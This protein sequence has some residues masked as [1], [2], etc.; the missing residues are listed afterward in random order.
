MNAC[1]RIS[2]DAGRNASTIFEVKCSTISAGYKGGHGNGQA[3]KHV[4]S[5]GDRTM[6]GPDLERAAGQA[7]KRKWQDSIRM[8]AGPHM[9]DPIRGHLPQPL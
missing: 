9:G 1:R 5:V 4:F 8:A 2:L 3:R 7:Q 6:F